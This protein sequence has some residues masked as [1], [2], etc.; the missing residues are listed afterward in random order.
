MGVLNNIS[1]I[2]SSTAGTPPILQDSAGTEVVQGC[3]AW[4]NFDGTTGIIRDSFNVSSV[5]RNG[6]G[7]YTLVFATPMGNVNYSTSGST[8]NTP[9][10]DTA[11]KIL[12][13]GPLT[14]SACRL[15]NFGTVARDSNNC[16]I[17]I[18]G[19]K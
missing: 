14:T 15:L 6:V 12:I 10:G 7:D 8:S 11:V 9:H 2:K 5:T 3:T 4:V 13:S 16:S 17:Q 18:F 1:T 19:G